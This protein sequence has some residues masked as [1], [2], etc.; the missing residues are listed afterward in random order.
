MTWITETRASYPFSR[1]KDTTKYKY[2]FS[3]WHHTN[4]YYIYIFPLILKYFLLCRISKVQKHRHLHKRGRKVSHGGRDY[5]H[6]KTIWWRIHQPSKWWSTHVTAVRSNNQK[7]VSRLLS[8]F[9]LKFFSCEWLPWII[10]PYIMHH[11]RPSYNIKYNAM[12]NMIWFNNP[13]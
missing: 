13:T 12:P 1:L 5:H 6:L 11:K 10:P 4:I 8:S 9:T 7:T 2:P 3:D